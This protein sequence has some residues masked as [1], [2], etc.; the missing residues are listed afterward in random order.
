MN[1]I[2]LRRILNELESRPDHYLDPVSPK[3]LG[4]LLS[5]LYGVDRSLV[6]YDDFACSQ[7]SEFQSPI[8]QR[9]CGRVL[10]TSRTSAQGVLRALSLLDAAVS[11]LGPREFVVGPY[12]DK[13]IF[14]DTL[15]II[16]T[17]R[18]GM[19]GEPT[20]Y[21]FAHL[22]RGVLLGQ[23]L[24]APSA[25]TESRARG[26]GPLEEASWHGFDR[27]VQDEC[28]APGCPWF[29]ALDCLEGFNVRGIRM[30]IELWR[31]YKASR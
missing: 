29:R 2:D 3:Y 21:W 13:D 27:F 11:A 7:L 16:D 6:A 28:R 25:P 5:G 4:A 9:L 22:A 12:F 1:P 20:V 23:E 30:A 15:Q 8:S 26:P 24:A 17:G 10:M 18:S 14:E 19:M 31:K